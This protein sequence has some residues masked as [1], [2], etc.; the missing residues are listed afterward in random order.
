MSVRNLLTVQVLILFLLP[1]LF[2][3][4][5]LSLLLFGYLRTYAIHYFGAEDT[6][7]YKESLPGIVTVMAYSTA[8]PP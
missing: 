7:M 2:L 5:F 8:L 3:N 4:T 1:F 6:Y